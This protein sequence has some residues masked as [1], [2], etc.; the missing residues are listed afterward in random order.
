MVIH[1]NDT[2]L[3]VDD[4]Q[5]NLNILVN[6][7]KS[8]YNLV[9]AKSG[10]ECLERAEKQNIDLILLDVMMPGMNGYQVI[11]KLK[12]KT[13]TA[14]IPVIFISAL[15]EVIDEEKGFLLGGVDYIIKPCHPSIIKARVKNQIQIVRHRKLLE[16]IALI[17]ALTEIPNRRNYEKQFVFEWKRA[18][19]NRHPLSIAI[20]DVDFFKQ[21]NDNYG[22][23]SGDQ[24]L[25]MVAMAIK[26]GLHR[27]S[28]F[29]AR[30]GGEEF[31]LILPD[32]AFE[33]ARTIAEKIRVMVEDLHIEHAFSNVSKWLTVSIGG[34]TRIPEVDEDI[35]A[36]IEFADRMLYEAKSNGRNRVLWA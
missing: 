13:Q 5:S 28:D 11:Q 18:S 30:Y 22:H 6:I 34:C 17:D 25:K 19:R 8:D 33:G 14:S 7:F 15:G 3:I 31:V 35:H 12:R 21:Y 32:T 9:I 26:T 20:I 23:A 29:A 27:P 2:I 10:D 24:S 4:E 1:E 16:N 36:I